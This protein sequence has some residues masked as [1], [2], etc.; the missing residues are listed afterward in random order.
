MLPSL[1]TPG[2]VVIATSRYAQYVAHEEDR[3]DLLFRIDKSI[4]HVLSLAK[5]AAVFLD[6][7]LHPPP[8]LCFELI[9]PLLLSWVFVF[10]RKGF[11][12][13]SFQLVFPTPNQS[14]TQS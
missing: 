5:K 8:V 11:R 4:P 10:S 12:L 2:P 13:M 9:G 14:A 7:A 1:T 6:V 3:P